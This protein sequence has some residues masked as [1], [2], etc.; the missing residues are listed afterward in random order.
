MQP[1]IVTVYE[2]VEGKENDS[3]VDPN[4]LLPVNG[5]YRL[6]ILHTPNWQIPISELTEERLLTCKS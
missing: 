6:L 2:T 4:A 5:F 1:A 3:R